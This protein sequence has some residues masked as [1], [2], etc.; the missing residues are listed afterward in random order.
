MR[1]GAVEVAVET[2]ETENERKNGGRLRTGRES[3]NSTGEV[4]RQ[5]DFEEVKLQVYAQKRLIMIRRRKERE[6]EKESRHIFH[7][8]MGG[9]GQREE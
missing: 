7:S 8:G 3:E 6:R 4:G 9:G 1:Q 5:I 2:D